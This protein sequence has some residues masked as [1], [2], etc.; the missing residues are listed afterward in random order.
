VTWIIFCIYLILFCWLVT[1]IPFFKRSG[2]SKVILISLFLIKVVAGIA[3]FQF[4]STPANKSTSDTWKFY[5]SSLAE[6]DLLLTDPITFGKSIFVSEHKAGNLFSDKQNYW[7]D[8]KNDV[9]VKIMAVINVFTGKN[10]L[11]N[12]IFFNFLFF[13]GLV[14]FYRLMNEVY[15]GNKWL[16]IAASFLIPSFLFWCSGVHKDGLIFS[17]LGIILWLFHQLLKK[18]FSVGRSFLFI[19]MLLLIFILRNY[20]VFVLMPALLIGWFLH[21]YPN[22]KAVILASAMVIGCLFMFTGKYLHPVLDIPAFI[23]SKHYQFKQL[24]GAKCVHF[25]GVNETPANF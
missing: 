12:I 9:M 4:Y 16:M 22:K 5:N 25:D 1:I 18:Q 8:L 23:V 17:A 11:A 7:N 24:Q 21:F 14:A 10:Y 15:N 20:L 19:L 13:F 2:L 3:Y 6:T